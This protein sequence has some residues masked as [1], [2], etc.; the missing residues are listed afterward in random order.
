[1]FYSTDVFLVRTDVFM[2]AVDP[3]TN[4]VVGKDTAL[5]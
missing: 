1:M 3:K 2:H 5:K 4:K